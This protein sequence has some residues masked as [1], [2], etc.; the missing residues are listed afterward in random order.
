MPSPAVFLPDT[1]HDL[2]DFFKSWDALPKQGLIPRLSDYLDAA[3]IELQPNVTIVDVHAPD[4]LTVRLFGTG[5]EDVSGIYPTS[6]DLMLLFSKAIQEKAKRMVW[7]VVTHPVGYVCV[8]RCQTAEGLVY[9][10]PA[11]CLPI[12]VAGPGPYGF[13]T[14]AS[15]VDASQTMMLEENL[16]MV[17][18]VQFVQWLDLGNGMPPVPPQ[19]PPQ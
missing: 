2:V 3:P 9:D 19:A 16:E 14:Y 4:K 7:V 18:D 13:I 5:L 1:P 11:I 15:V 17:Q 6:E 8:R 12:A 10:V